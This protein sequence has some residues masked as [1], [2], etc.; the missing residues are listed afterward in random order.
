MACI[1]QGI[2]TFKRKPI[3]CMHK[4]S[5]VSWM[6]LHND[7]KANLARWETQAA[8]LVKLCDIRHRNGCFGYKYILSSSD[9]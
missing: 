3:I 5:I 4:H 2:F 9:I 1:L 8:R 7:I 6:Y